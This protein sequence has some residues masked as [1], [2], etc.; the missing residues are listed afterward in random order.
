MTKEEVGK[1]VKEYYDLDIEVKKLTQKKDALKV[2]LKE[3]VGDIEESTEEEYPFGKQ[4]L[5]MQNSVRRTVSLNANALNIIETDRSF[6]SI[7]DSVT[8]T[9]RVVRAD[10]IEALIKDDELTKRQ[11]DL[12][13][14]QGKTI[15]LSIK[16]KK[17][18]Q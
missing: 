15:A 11:I 14:D 4:V 16:L 10:K 5:V 7:K 3:Y 17:T 8:E 12:L 9:I 13:Y 1:K 6:R 2:E 18:K